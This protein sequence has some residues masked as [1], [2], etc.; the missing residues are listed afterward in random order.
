MASNKRSIE[1]LLSGV[2]AKLEALR[3]KLPRKETTLDTSIKEFNALEASPPTKETWITARNA[4]QFIREECVRMHAREIW[5]VP[6]VAEALRDKVREFRI[7]ALENNLIECLD[8]LEQHIDNKV[9]VKDAYDKAIPIEA[10]DVHP[11]RYARFYSWKFCDLT[12]S[13]VL[14]FE[15]GIRYK[16]KYV[17]KESMYPSEYCRV[18][19][20]IYYAA[21]ASIEEMGN[22]SFPQNIKTEDLCLKRYL[23]VC[24]MRK[25]VHRK[26]TLFQAVYDILEKHI[27]DIKRN[28][29][30]IQDHS[31]RQMVHDLHAFI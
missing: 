31:L 3:G 30:T 26:D 10:F 20:K 15:D 2:D 7:S 12:S 18:E 13:N 19:P 17:Q 14:R 1:E 16:V 25:C 21:D 8:I 24:L 23:N 27:L 22:P 6:E 9:M 4:L 11:E 29:E 28:L 5:E